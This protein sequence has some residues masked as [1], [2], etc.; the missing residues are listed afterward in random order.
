MATER[1][2]KRTVDSIQPPE[3]GDQLYWDTELRGFGLRVT[4]R[5]VKS[6]ILQYRLKGKPARRITLGLHGSPWTADG[7]RKD[8]ER[9]LIKIRQG[10]DP[11]EEERLKEL[12]ERS[13]REAAQ[14]AQADADRLAEEE[15]RDQEEFS[16]D[17]YADRFVELY[18]KENWPDSWVDGQGVLKRVKP[19]FAGKSVKEIVK[20]DVVALMDSYARRPGA[21]KF[22]HSVVRKLFNW[23]V[24]RGDLERSPIAGMKAPKAVA[25]RRRVLSPEELL[26]AWIAAGRLERPWRQLVRLLIV[27]LQRRSEVAGL[28]WA[29][30]DVSQRMWQLPEERAKNDQ[31]HRVAL[32]A[33]AIAELRT[34]EP[35]DC[36]PVL[37]TRGSVTVSGFSKVKKK[38]DVLM[39]E[40]LRERAEK[41]GQDPGKVKLVPW[42]YHDLR[43]TGTTNLQALGVPVEVTEAIL[44][45]ISGTTG[46]IAGVYNL[47]RYDREKRIALDAWSRQLSGLVKAGA[48]A[49]GF[50]V[51]P[52][53]RYAA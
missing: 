13:Q 52:F 6:Y 35:K 12:E 2:T 8:A 45:H 34:L 17:A 20:A 24:D 41:R 49:P 28:D 30:I 1:L 25:P 15:R 10:I 47:Y 51:V 36:G 26:A 11:I 48:S 43:R 39:V 38:L 5:G 27:T 9:R 44:N 22:V 14:Q 32:N 53:A 3:V 42:R 16:F 33:L 46:G 21:R 4:P 19:F 23:A 40:V 7:A 31:P 50:D 29:E 18:L 37:T